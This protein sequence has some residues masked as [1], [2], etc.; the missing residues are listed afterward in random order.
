MT[1]QSITNSATLSHFRSFLLIPEEA[2]DMWHSYNLIAVDD[3]VTAS[4]I[5]KVCIESVIKDGLFL[6][7]YFK[8]QN[9]TATGS[10]S[11]SR[12]RTMLTI[13]VETIDYDTQACVLRLK[14]RNQEENQYVKVSYH[15]I[16]I[17]F[18]N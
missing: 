17:I 3:I 9:E 1:N 2:E 12:V 5:R 15:T 13:K 4:T 14:G 7:V 18:L 16:I 11:S 8:V 6:F 10:S